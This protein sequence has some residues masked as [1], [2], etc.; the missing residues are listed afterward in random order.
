M[1]CSVC[2]ADG[3]PQGTTRVVP[4]YGRS[5]T[6]YG[7]NGEYL[8]RST[9]NTQGGRTYNNMYEYSA[10]ST[11]TYNGGQRFYQTSP[12]NVTTRTHINYGRGYGHFNS[13]SHST[14]KAHK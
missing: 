5:E 11:S 8:G 7:G 13:Q 3:F 6:Y 4:G 1:L 9:P 12:P 14:S 10:R 2:M